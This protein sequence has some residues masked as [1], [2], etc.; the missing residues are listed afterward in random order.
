M[1]L[2]TEF[3]NQTAYQD[4][5]GNPDLAKIDQQRFNW[6]EYYKIKFNGVGTIKS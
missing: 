4:E 6:L 3:S 5:D 2:I 1:V